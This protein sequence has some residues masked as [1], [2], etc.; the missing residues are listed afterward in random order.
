M[1]VGKASEHS[2]PQPPKKD[3]KPNSFNSFAAHSSFNN[4]NSFNN[5]NNFHNMNKNNQF[6]NSVVK[7]SYYSPKTINY[8]P[9][10]KPKFLPYQQHKEPHFSQS[11]HHN[12]NVKPKTPPPMFR[13][14]TQVEYF[15]PQVSNYFFKGGLCLKVFLEKL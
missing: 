6:A 7:T 8:V 5:L 13:H 1:I 10:N 11:K 3:Y 9:E 4:M 2:K 15:I 12:Y 14:A